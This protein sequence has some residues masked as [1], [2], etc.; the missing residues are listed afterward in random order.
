MDTQ[1]EMSDE[2]AKALL[3]LLVDYF[4]TYKDENCHTLSCASL[5]SDLVN[6]LPRE[7]VPADGIGHDLV[8]LGIQL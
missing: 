5:M 7:S 8:R 2:S 4:W 1:R 6:S 3:A